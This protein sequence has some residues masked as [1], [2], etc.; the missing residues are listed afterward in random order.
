[1]KLNSPIRSSEDESLPFQEE[2]EDEK[3]WYANFQSDLDI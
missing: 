3:Y 2:D 1:V